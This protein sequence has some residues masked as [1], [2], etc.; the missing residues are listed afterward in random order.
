[1]LFA[2]KFTTFAQQCMSMMQTVLA[3]MSSVKGGSP[4]ELSRSHVRYHVRMV[5]CLATAIVLKHMKRSIHY[6]AV[7]ELWI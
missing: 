3:V 2:I 1:M 5:T 4:Q 6:I 7:V